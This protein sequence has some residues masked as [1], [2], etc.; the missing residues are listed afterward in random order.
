MR[1]FLLIH[2]NHITNA[3]QDQKHAL[4]TLRANDSKVIGDGKG[5]ESYIRDIEVE[6]DNH[7]AI[8]ETYQR[9]CVKP[10]EYYIKVLF[11]LIG[12]PET[13]PSCRCYDLA[14]TSDGQWRCANCKRTML[15]CVKEGLIK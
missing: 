4:D 2:N 15:D 14:K 11:A 9:W 7:E 1:I 10:D 13:C 6:M 12:L 3:I 8:F 5:H